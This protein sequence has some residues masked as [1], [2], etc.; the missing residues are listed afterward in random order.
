MEGAMKSK[1]K[2]V[3]RSRKPELKKVVRK[4]RSTSKRTQSKKGFGQH[5]R[6]ILVKVWPEISGATKIVELPESQSIVSYAL[7]SR[8]ITTM[9]LMWYS[10]SHGPRVYAHYDDANDV[11]YV[12][13]IIE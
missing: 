3:K 8:K 1:T 4:T 9:T 7:P 13:K 6:D 10:F 11:C 5:Q 12:G 2:Q